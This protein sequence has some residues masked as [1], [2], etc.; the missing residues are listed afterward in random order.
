MHTALTLIKEFKTRTSKNRKYDIL[1]S[2]TYYNILGIITISS[3]QQTDLP[4]LKVADRFLAGVHRLLPEDGPSNAEEDEDVE[5]N[6][7]D[8]RGIERHQTILLSEEAPEV[9][10][11]R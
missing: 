7:E 5:E 3:V 1:T 6:A 8:D 9:D 11:C 10:I 2:N 4:P